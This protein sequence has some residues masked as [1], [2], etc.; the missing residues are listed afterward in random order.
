MAAATRE[1]GTDATGGPGGRP[2]RRWP[3]RYTDAAWLAVVAVAAVAVGL[4]LFPATSGPAPSRVVV[5]ALPYWNIGNGTATVLSQRGAFTE[6]SPWMYGLAS[7][8]QIETQYPA[9]QQAEVQAEIARLRA[10][11]LRVVPTLANVD[12]GRFAYQPVAG[13]LHDP[14]RRKQHV[15]AITALVSRH[16]YA[17]IDIDYEDLRAGDR[18]VFTAFISELAAALHARDKILSVA[19][20]AKVT[21]AGYAPRNVAQDY[22]AIGRVADQ[23]RI[24]AYGY[25]WDTS[26]P[27]PIAPVSWIRAVIRYAKREIPAAKVVLGVGLYG[28]DWSQGSATEV[29]WLRA[30]QLS[31]RYNARPRYDTTSQAPWFTYT[32]ADGHR[33]TVWFENEASARAKF[34]IAKGSQIGG[35]FLWMFGYEDTGTWAALRDTLPLPN[36]PAPPSPH[37][38]PP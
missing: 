12:Q 13:I 37:P 14:E 3:R 23:V 20:F 28:Y 36:Q 7:N 1:P 2:G 8:G 15:A 17:G 27:G 4:I 30:F 38:S 26:P 25:H 6:V 16:H 31:T 9:G 33:H 35:V 32:D 11:G 34:E 19:L 21:D 5:A 24:M 10:A 18:R 29:T 22:A